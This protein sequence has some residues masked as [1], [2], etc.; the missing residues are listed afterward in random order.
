MKNGEF[1][2]KKKRPN[3]HDSKAIYKELGIIAKN[4]SFE[5]ENPDQV[6]PKALEANKEVLK[7][8]WKATAKK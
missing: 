5:L 2:V 6:M 7:A 4:G 3:I 8:L 1:D